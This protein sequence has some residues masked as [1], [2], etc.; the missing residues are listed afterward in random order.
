MFVSIDNG[1]GLLLC[2]SF[3]LDFTTSM[4]D[5]LSSGE[6]LIIFESLRLNVKEMRS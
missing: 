3:D 6:E 4:R 5:C 2:L 1:R